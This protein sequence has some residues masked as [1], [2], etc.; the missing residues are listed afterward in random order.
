MPAAHPVALATDAAS[1]LADAAARPADHHSRPLFE[2]VRIE[3]A[4]QNAGRIARRHLLRGSGGCATVVNVPLEQRDDAAARLRDALAGID[5]V[6]LAYLFGSRSRGDARVDSDFDIA[7]LLTPDAA[8]AERGGTIRRLA[9]RLGREVSAAYVDL[10]VLN[11]A[12]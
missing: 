12:P 9:A 7:V 6:R 10:V 4:S 1:G 8:A 2:H 5:E 11:D 3:E